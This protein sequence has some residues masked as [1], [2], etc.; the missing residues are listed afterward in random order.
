MISASLQPIEQSFRSLM[1]TTK[2]IAP[3]ASLVL[4][5]HSGVFAV[6]RDDN[7]RGKSRK[8]DYM[9]TMVL[10]DP[11]AR[12]PFGVS[13]F[14]KNKD[15]IPERVSAGQ[16]IKLTTLKIQ[17]FNGKLQ[18]LSS[19]QTRL[20]LFPFPLTTALP[21]I[22]IPLDA[23]V[24]SPLDT[25][26]A[27]LLHA[28][29]TRSNDPS[30]S[31]P[32]P[33]A[34]TL[35]ANKRNV[36]TI[37]KLKEPKIVFDLYCQVVHVLVKSDTLGQLVILVSDFTKAGFQLSAPCRLIANGVTVSDENLLFPVSKDALCIT[38]WD[39]PPPSDF[40][41]TIPRLAEIERGSYIYF[42]NLFTKES[43]LESSTFLAATPALEA[44]LHSE[45]TENSM[46]GR[47]QVLGLDHPQVTLLR[48]RVQE[49][50]LQ[51]NRDVSNLTITPAH[52]PPTTIQKLLSTAHPIPSRF[53]FEAAVIDH[54]PIALQDFS[55]ILCDY[56]GHSFVEDKCGKCGHADMGKWRFMFSLLLGDGDAYVPVIVSGEEAERFLKFD[57]QNMHTHSE[58]FANLRSAVSA[59]WMVGGEGQPRVSEARRAVWCVQSFQP[60]GCDVGVRFKLIATEL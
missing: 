50:G 55:R 11:T 10:M 18:G 57:A 45:R 1:D 37:D 40:P 59:L 29:Y 2:G 44:T 39:D 19:F 42:R 41:T 28:W 54:L 17:Q 25:Q 60:E 23:S 6:V 13:M 35:L 14:S 49:Q 22:T 56:C 52:V 20:I 16:V 58:S 32:E 43:N 5:Q 9:L 24:P 3:I 15:A 36:W 26:L 51:M 8:G 53:K 34:A 7:H 33:L 12:I 38:I 48:A 21:V 47:W 46:G 31:N 27:S 30:E 4:N